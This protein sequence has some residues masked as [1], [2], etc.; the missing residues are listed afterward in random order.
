MRPQPIRLKELREEKGLTQE[1]AA[2]LMGVV[3]RQYQRYERG[4]GEPKLAGWIFLADFYGV[5][6]DYLVGRSEG[7][8]REGTDLTAPTLNFEEKS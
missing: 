6:L 7:P 2:A 3:P 4:E 1:E 8:G 5:S